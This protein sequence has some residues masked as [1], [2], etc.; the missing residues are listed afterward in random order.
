M[1]MCLLYVYVIFK[2]HACFTTVL[3][4]WSGSESVHASSST[5][6]WSGSESVLQW[7][8]EPAEMFQ[9][10]GGVVQR[11]CCSGS[12]SL[13]QW[14]RERAAV[15]ERACCSGS[16]SLLQ[17]FRESAGVVQSAR[18]HLYGIWLP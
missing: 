7:F 8:K 1:P 3:F 17:W 13:P 16:K 6:C 18:W 12:E 4:C 5:P 10:C 15:L 2:E 11:A 14:F 9:E